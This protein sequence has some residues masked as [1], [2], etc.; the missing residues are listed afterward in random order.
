MSCLPNALVLL[1]P[2]VDNG[3]EGYGYERVKGIFPA[4]SPL[5]NLKPG[6]PPTIFLVGDKDKYVPRASAE[7]YRDTMK[8][9]R[10]PLRA[11]S[12]RRPGPHLLLIQQRQAPLLLSKPE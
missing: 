9:E 12:V 6:L 7:K 11:F 8:Q 10:R 3:P 2:V 5:H 1:N 4:I